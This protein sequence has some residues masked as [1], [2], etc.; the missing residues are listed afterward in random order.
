MIKT[1]HSSLKWQGISQAYIT[2]KQIEYQGNKRR[3]TKEEK[4]EKKEAGAAEARV[5]V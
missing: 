2:R 1:L 4:E 3:E 5:G